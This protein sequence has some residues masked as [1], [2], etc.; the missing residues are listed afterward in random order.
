[1]IENSN[2]SEMENVK[3]SPMGNSNSIAPSIKCS[4]RILIVVKIR[5]RKITC[6]C[7]TLSMAEWPSHSVTEIYDAIIVASTLLVAKALAAP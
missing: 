7:R 4:Q 6:S 5:T 2:E 1:V 3:L